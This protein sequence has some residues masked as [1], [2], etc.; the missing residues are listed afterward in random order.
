MQEADRI[1]AS[2]YPHSPAGLCPGNIDWAIV[3]FWLAYLGI[4]LNVTLFLLL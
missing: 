4:Y 2:P 1:M 3:A